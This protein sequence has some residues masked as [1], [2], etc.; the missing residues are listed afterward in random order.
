MSH[1]ECC[2]RL[3]RRSYP[4]ASCPTA[5]CRIAR[6][7]TAVRRHGRQA[8]KRG[9]RVGSTLGL[10]SEVRAQAPPQKSSAG[11][12]Q[13][14][15]SIKNNDLK[16]CCL[17]KFDVLLVVTGNSMLSKQLVVKLFVCMGICPGPPARPVDGPASPPDM[18]CCPVFKPA[19]SAEEFT[20]LFGAE[21]ANKDSAATL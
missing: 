6:R 16:T 10:A 20:L 12:G 4:I 15:V 8:A 11:T 9:A 18:P 7:F 5:P 21:W 13:I 2:S 17:D 1:A 3:H 19:L 14:H